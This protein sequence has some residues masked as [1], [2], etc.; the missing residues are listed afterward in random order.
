M[1]S[2]LACDR[3]REAPQRPASWGLDLQAG[4]A[5]WALVQSSEFS[6]LRSARFL[7]HLPSGPER[8]RLGLEARIT[9]RDFVNGTLVGAGAAVLGASSS[10]VA[11]SSRSARR[12]AANEA[13]TAAPGA[14][15]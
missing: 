11:A 10:T 14:A 5:V 1:S 15:E 2:R 3:P 13:A 8:R 4:C 6:R 9:R 7:S 12:R